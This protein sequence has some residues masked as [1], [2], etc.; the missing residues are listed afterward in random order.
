M[1]RVEEA[2]KIILSHPGDLW[3]EKIPFELALGSV[4]A[5]D[6]RADRDIP[7]FN[8][9]TVDGI[10]INYKAFQKGIRVFKI[11]DFQ[12]A[13]QIPVDT[14]TEDECTEIMTGAA[15]PGTLDSVIRYEDLNIKD[16]T[17]TVTIENITKGQ[18]IHARAKDKKEGE[19]VALAN[20]VITPALIAIA[21]SIGKVEL[22]VK[23]FPN[24]TV[25]STGDELV[26]VNK[27][28]SLFQIRRSN[29]YMLKA[30]LQTRGIDATLIHLFDNLD[31]VTDELYRLFTK[32]KLSQALH[33]FRWNDVIII[34]GG[35]SMG[36]FDY[37]HKALRELRVK[38]LFHKVLQRP[39]KPFWFGADEDD[40]LV[41][42][43]PGNPV[44]AFMCMHRYFFPWLDASLGLGSQQ[45]Q[46][47]VLN[48]DFTFTPS[49][50]YFFAGE[51]K[52]ERAGPIMCNTC[53]RKW[54]RRFCKPARSRC[55]YGTSD[56]KE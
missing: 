55:L 27:T 48:E 19:I 4:L 47:A 44:S 45:K 21:A 6:L 35:V 43:F 37:V 20:Q 3:V 24:V 15:M 54:F 8:R 49:L 53:G 40:T 52:N 42:A 38:E 30:L 25:V 17:A 12:L 31:I 10:A 36:R 9:T 29:G 23:R 1:I 14:N 18:N 51:I 41:F 56:G 26:E 5:E 7:P 11:K 16:G 22:M 33:P 46:Y 32:A 39:G 13:G 50:Q 34:T 28:P 2:E